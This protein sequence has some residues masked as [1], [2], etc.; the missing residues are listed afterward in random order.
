MTGIAL[1]PGY[2]LRTTTVEDAEAA[3]AVI[4]AVGQAEGD[5]SETT[6]E[7]VLSDWAGIDLANDAV[8]V[9]GP[10]GGVVALAEVVNRANISFSV[11]G[12]VHPA[13]QGRGIGRALVD[14]GE[15][16]AQERMHLA[17][18]DARVVVQH[19]A[20]STS[21]HT[22]QLLESAGYV[23]VRGV[24]TMEVNFDEPPPAP[25]WPAGITVRTYQPGQDER[26]TYEAVEDSFRDLWGRPRNTF[27]RFLRLTSGDGF[28][29]SL[30]FLAMAGDEVAGVSLCKVV[31]GQAIVQTLGVLRP[32]RGQGLGLALLRH[33]FGVFWERGIRNVWL[34]VDAESLTGAPRLYQRAGMHVTGSYIIYQKELRP[35]VDYSQH[36]Q[37]E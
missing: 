15:R 36:A 6:A 28:D 22:R 25:E 34:S 24:Y 26:R 11:Y 13:H 7:E 3:A 29:P 4:T 23:P 9:E 12:Y 32:Y 31:P 37:D 35:G 21:D 20:R 8:V 17:P 5:P 10:E 1:P 33:S 30:W 27:E 14:W 19:Y 18:A 2:R 16:W